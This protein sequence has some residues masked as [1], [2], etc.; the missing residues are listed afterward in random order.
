MLKPEHPEQSDLA[1]I[2]PDVREFQYQI[3]EQVW[4]NRYLI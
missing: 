1:R 3:P 4:K 2:Y